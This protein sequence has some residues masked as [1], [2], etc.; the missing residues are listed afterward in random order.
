MALLHRE[1]LLPEATAEGNN[2]R[3]VLKPLGWLQTG[4]S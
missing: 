4:Q 3:I 1:K 2:D